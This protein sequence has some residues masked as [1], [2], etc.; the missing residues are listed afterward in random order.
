MPTDLHNHHT[1][2][3]YSHTASGNN[4]HNRWGHNHQCTETK[5]EAEAEAE[6]ATVVP[7]A[8][9]MDHSYAGPVS[10]KDICPDTAPNRG[11]REDRETPSH[12]RKIPVVRFPRMGVPT[13]E[14]A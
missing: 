11:G 6:E 2:T 10:K 9:H 3:G 14:G 12:R 7:M 1:H 13:I 5:V 8:M 4:H